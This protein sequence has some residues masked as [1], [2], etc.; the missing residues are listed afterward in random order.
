[1]NSLITS[2]CIKNI[3]QQSVRYANLWYPLPHGTAPPSYEES[4]RG[5]HNIADDDDAQQ[6]PIGVLPYTPR[7]VVYNFDALQQRRVQANDSQP[8]GSAVFTMALPEAKRNVYRA[9]DIAVDGENRAEV[10]TG[11][12]SSATVTVTL[13]TADVDRTVAE[14]ERHAAKLRANMAEWT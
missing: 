13:G 5:N 11:V 6:L 12:E 2:V 10:Q 9:L 14:N 7:Y 8:Q 3:H 1:M 4:L